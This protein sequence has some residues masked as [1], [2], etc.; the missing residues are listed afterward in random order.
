VKEEEL[1]KLP[2]DKYLLTAANNVSDHAYNS[3]NEK[4]V[5]KDLSNLEPFKFFTI[6]TS[7]KMNKAI[8]DDLHREADSNLDESFRISL[9]DL[10]FDLEDTV[11]T[12]FSTDIWQDEDKLLLDDVNID[13]MEILPN[14]TNELDSINNDTRL[15]LDDI[16]SSV[17]D[18]SES[19][20][21]QENKKNTTDGLP[22]DSNRKSDSLRNLSASKAATLDNTTEK[23]L[24]NIT[25]KEQLKDILLY[26]DGLFANLPEPI[27]KEFACSEYYDKYNSLFDNLGI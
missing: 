7:K 5:I 20:N 14:N 22:D 24:L 6:T 17:E 25:K 2:F 13:H 19:V 16:D 26:L 12:S 23:E 9:D 15:T 1:N 18:I 21:N 4:A 8:D 3:H 11:N 10:S 27:I